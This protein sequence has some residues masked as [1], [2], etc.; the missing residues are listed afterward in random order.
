MKSIE[1]FHG[2]CA[3][4]RAPIDEQSALGALCACCSENCAEVFG[5]D[6]VEIVGHRTLVFTP[7]FGKYEYQFDWRGTKV[8][9]NGQI[10]TVHR[11]YPTCCTIDF[12][13]SKN[14]WDM[15][16][17]N[18]GCRRLK[19]I[20]KEGGVDVEPPALNLEPHIPTKANL[21]DAPILSIQVNMN[22]DGDVRSI[23][24]GSHSIGFG[25]IGRPSELPVL[26]LLTSFANIFVRYKFGLAP[27]F[28]HEGGFIGREFEARNA[29]GT[30]GGCG[31]LVT[32]NPSANLFQH[33]DNEADFRAL[34]LL[35]GLVGMS[36]TKQEGRPGVLAD[37]S[38]HEVLSTW[39]N[40]MET[41][42]R[43]DWRP[44]KADTVDDLWKNYCLMQDILV[45]VLAPADL[46]AA[47]N[48]AKT[49]AGAA[50]GCSC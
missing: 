49:N 35:K 41:L 29:G 15:P 1:L 44:C 3:V 9:I 30:I 17:H 12:P 26:P 20:Y 37:A 25:R 34:A 18:L 10:G 48:F 14:G 19:Q 42:L 40:I 24:I 45:N 13:D 11:T 50:S 32:M 31:L 33:V 8:M 27:N 43:Y 38:A 6:N 21:L 28:V 2:K 46:S 4:C 5:P 47:L 22:E 16:V 7:L 23:Q 36:V 39:V